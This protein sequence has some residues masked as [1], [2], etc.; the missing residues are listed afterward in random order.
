MKV[1]ARAEKDGPY[2]QSE[3]KEIYRRYVDGL[4]DA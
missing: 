4:L 1:C 2:K 3:R